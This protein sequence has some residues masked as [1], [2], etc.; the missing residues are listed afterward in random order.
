MTLFFRLGLLLLLVA[1]STLLR[2]WGL[3]L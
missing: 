3:A 2:L 1:L